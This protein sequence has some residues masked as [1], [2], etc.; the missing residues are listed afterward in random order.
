MPPFFEGDKVSDLYLHVGLLILLLLF[1][2]VLVARVPMLRGQGQLAGGGSVLNVFYVIGSLLIAAGYMAELMLDPEAKLQDV[3][4]GA[5]PSGVRGLYLA[6]LCCGAIMWTCSAGLSFAEARTGR[7]SG[8][9]LRLW[10]MLA[11]LHACLRLAADVER[12]AT[13]AVSIGDRSPLVRMA[14]CVLSVALGLC[15]LCEPDSP[16]EDAYAH[17]ATFRSFSGATGLSTSLNAR[18][19]PSEGPASPQGLGSPRG[20]GSTERGLR[21]TEATASYWSRW[22]FSWLSGI[23]RLGS[24]RAL[25]QTDLYD[26][27]VEDATAYNSAKLSDAWQREQQRRP[28]KGVFL[29]AFHSA[30]GRYFWVTGV[31]Q[32]VNTALMFA[33]PILINTLVKYLSGE[34]SAP[35]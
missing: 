18:L 4:A 13:S 2:L 9:S 12:V 19:L 31:F 26:L 16:S 23:L 29:R 6:C 15:A 24:R 34:V 1:I 35:G 25:E 33:N 21:N 3:P 28:G 27:Q 7:R 20:A 32:V 22:T 14:T 5:S 11:M 30:Y 10:L 17:N 8:R